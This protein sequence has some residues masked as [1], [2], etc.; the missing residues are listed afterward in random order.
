MSLLMNLLKTTLFALLLLCTVASCSK[1]PIAEQTADFTIDLSLAEQNDA[2]FAQEV[3]TLINEHRTS[4]GIDVIEI[5]TQFSSAYAVEH[6]NYMIDMSQINHDHF[7]IRSAAL[8]STGAH[9]VGEN[10]AYGYNTAESVVNAWLNSPSHRDNIEGNYTHAGFGIKR[11][12]ES[13]TYYF[14]QLFYKV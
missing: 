9:Q 7:G 5:G 12:T 13:N 8:Q 10:V 2:Q 14:T 3:L 4:I 6:T 1:D 11:C